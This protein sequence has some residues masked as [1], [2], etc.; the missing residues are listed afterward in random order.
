MRGKLLS[1]DKKNLEYIKSIAGPITNLSYGSDSGYI[2]YF[3]NKGMIEYVQA[4]DENCETCKEWDTKG[5]RWKF[6]VYSPAHCAFCYCAG[7]DYEYVI[8]KGL[9][10]KY[11]TCEECKEK[12][13]E[14][15]KNPQNLMH[16]SIYGKFKNIEKT[17][18]F[19]RKDEENLDNLV[20]NKIES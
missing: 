11:I 15:Y 3:L 8:F 5:N 20:N 17:G 1:F 9:K 16:R 2:E 10:Q 14:I 18:M 7:Y 4:C 13:M 12:V 19:Y 6:N